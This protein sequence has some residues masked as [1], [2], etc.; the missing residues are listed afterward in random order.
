MS[1]FNQKNS[2][3]QYL[4]WSVANDSKDIH[5]HLIKQLGEPAL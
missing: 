1:Y 4:F 3:P 2:I 5:Y